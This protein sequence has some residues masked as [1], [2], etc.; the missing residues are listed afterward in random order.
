MKHAGLAQSALTLLA[1]LSLAVAPV[2]AT[3]SAHAAEGAAADQLP[4]T[5]SADALPT[6]QVLNGVVRDQVVVG[7]TVYAVGEFTSVQPVGSA[8]PVARANAL[9]YNIET[10]ELLDWAPQTNGAIQSIAAMPDG[11]RLFIGGAFSKL[12]E[13]TVW[14]VAAVDP[15]TAE[16]K[17]LTAAANA[18]VFAV[19]VSADGSTL[20]V[21]GAFTQINNKERLRF[22]AVDLNTKKLLDVKASIPNF[23]VRAIA[24]EPNGTGVAI[25]GSFTSVNGSTSP[26]YG[27]AILERDGS[28]RRNNLTSVVRSGNTYGGIMDLK[29]DAQ[30]LYGAAYTQSRSHGNL[31]G[32]FRA[33]WNTGNVA[34]IA[35][36]HG[37]SY[38]V[39]P[40]GDVVY[41]ANH[42]HDC[43]NI[44]GFPDNTK[45]YHYALAYANYET[46]KVRTNTAS[47]YYDFGGQPGTTNLNWYPEF[48]PG[49]YTG[50]GQATWTVEG[51]DRYIVF[52]GEFTTVNG[53]SQRGLTRFARRDIA[54]NA[55]GPVNKGGNYKLT[56]S[57]P[58]A[59]IVTL[60]FTA[61]WDRDDKTL[62]YAVFRDTL[63]G[64]PISVQDVTAGFW[65]LPAL[66][67][68]DTVEPG[69]THQ[70]AVVV[71]DPWGAST[72]S[73]WVSVTAGQGQ[74]M[75]N[76]GRQ[77]IGDG[78][79][80]YWPLDEASGAKSAYDLV[81]GRNLTYRG[82]S[83]TTGAASV[84]SQGASVTFSPGNNNGG[85]WQWW[86]RN[87][88]QNSSYSWA[89]QTSAAAAPAAFTV[90]AWFRTNSTS[91]GEI[92]G[93]SSSSESEG[94][95]KDRML[96]LSGNGTVNYMLYPGTVKAI[97]S[98]AG[99]N[100]NAWHHVVATTDPVAGSVLYLDGKEAAS[101]PAMTSGQSYNGYWRIGGDTNSGLPNA[102]SSGYLTG[103]IDEVAVYAKALS[104]QQVSAHHVTG[105][106]GELP[107]LAPADPDDIAGPAGDAQEDDANQV[108]RADGVLLTDSFERESAR[109]WGAADFGGNWSSAYGVSRMSVDGTAGVITMTGAGTANSVSSPIID[110]T[111][112]DS[113]VDL[114]LDQA[115]TG[116]GAYVTY[117]GR[118]NDAGRYQVQLDISPT[119]VV[120]MTVSKKVG[121]TQTSLGTAR[122]DGTY[123]AGQKLHLRFVVDGAQSTRLQ[124][125][126]WVG[127]E[128]EPE[129]WAVDTTDDDAALATPGSVGIVT[130]TSGRADT[131]ELTLR[132]D[133]LVVKKVE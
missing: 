123:T 128:P 57:S 120:A 109:G 27:M 76:Y 108:E 18:K 86:G 45:N 46:G 36:C 70:Y 53:Q 71:T 107:Q 110:A 101:D 39:F 105:T 74:G 23:S 24:A 112:T 115:T 19:E 113:T 94:A 132:V 130:F 83:Y 103:S 97:S 84:L 90:E 119:G 63:D 60:S 16:R 72:R 124:L 133:D 111:S 50:L 28:I 9:A 66:T 14:R 6:P 98:A 88:Q 81:G 118:A 7:D 40:S 106:T 52:G 80:N 56:A 29:A 122:M 82:S 116:A 41:A 54:P 68:T 87:R 102:G 59:G 77:V 31:E 73:D 55:Q 4:E 47:G 127:D 10:G 79:V 91:G 62:S 8:A 3:T 61:N 37:D 99:F 89:A 65:E 114:V 21:G 32:V 121:A 48:T 95:S 2:I 30:G 75:A 126:G 38:D 12:N 33:D 125:K 22:A 67:A 85:W 35:D 44:G 42:G 1:S 43:S 64:Q 15:I 104:A 51:N 5:V 11:S 78:A 92:V 20:Y 58:A 25:G 13:E 93:F 49:T 129:A 96:Y 26:G 17:P 34:Y 131:S 100:D 117:V 69:S